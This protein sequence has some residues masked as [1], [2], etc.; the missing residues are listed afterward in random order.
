MM[1]VNDITENMWRANDTLRNVMRDIINNEEVADKKA[2]L[3][4][5]VDEYSTY[6]KNKVNTAAIAKGDSFF[7]VPETEIQ[8]AGKKVSAKNL[9]ALKMAQRALSIVINEAEPDYKLSEE[10]NDKEKEEGEV[11]K[12]ELTEIM[13]QAMEVALKPINDRLDKIEKEDDTNEK[14]KEKELAKGTED[15]AEIVKSV[16]DEALIPLESRLEKVEKSRGIA[17][18]LEGEEKTEKIEKKEEGTDVFEGYF[19]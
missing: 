3:L 14:E 4:Q 12:E 17:R 16:I 9:E 6:M 13:K 1:A 7:D 8:K 5:A 15:I 11:K 19:A 18:S 2:A 10:N